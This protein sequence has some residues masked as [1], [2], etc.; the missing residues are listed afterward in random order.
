VRQGIREEARALSIDNVEI[1]YRTH[2]S[3]GE[4]EEEA[5]DAA[6]Q[7]EVDG[8][9]TFP[10]IPR[11]WQSWMRRATSSGIPSGLRGD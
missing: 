11:P 1:E 5:F 4:G 9:I 3:L 2:P 6:L 10:A 8:I 7:A